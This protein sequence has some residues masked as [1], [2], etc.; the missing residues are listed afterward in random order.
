MREAMRWTAPMNAPSP[1]PTMPSLILLPVL[2]SLRP[3]MAMPVS[4]LAQSDRAA[5]E[6]VERFVGDPDDVMLDELGALARA[7]LRVLEAAFPFEH[8]PGRIAVLRHL[9]KDAREVGLPVAER[10]EPP[11]PF[12]PRRIARIDALP[13]RRIELGVLHMKCRNPLVVDV[14]ELEIVELLQDEMRGI[15]IDG[16][17]LVSF[18]GVE[19]TLEA[20][21][22]EQVLARVDLVGD[23]DAG[24][25]EG[26]QDRLPALGE[27]FVRGLDQPR[28]A[29]RPRIDIGPGERTRE[30]RMGRE[31]E[32]LR[33]LGGMQHLL[34]RPLLPLLW[35]PVSLLRG[36]GVEGFVIGRVDRDQ[37]TDHMRRE[38]GNRQTVVLR[39][40]G[41][42]VAIGL[43]R[44]GFGE[45]EEP[46]LPG[47]NLDALIAER[48]RP[49]A[50]P[51]QRIE[52]RSVAGELRQEYCRSLDHASH[53]PSSFRALAR[54]TSKGEAR[55]RASPTSRRS[56]RRVREVTVLRAAS[57]MLA[58]R[59]HRESPFVKR[60]RSRLPATPPSG[61]QFEQGVM[62][63]VDGR[64]VV[65]R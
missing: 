7:V 21:S 17:A 43:R 60:G 26:V 49:L 32:V 48:S 52:R 8:R 46:S 13:P 51:V 22:V 62:K 58:R 61:Q 33:R 31:A 3:S 18:D 42:L 50:H 28:R 16:A 2:A 12:D 27:L 44:G 14:D 37:L 9:R 30:G 57:N 41:D 23:V 29:L 20:R 53:D 19:E 65:S 55:G 15:V 40:P 6:V 47:R 45:V 24:L 34:N 39:G 5:G 4:P 36:E 56:E 54:L 38:L 11:G 10:P 63:G 59:L 64:D 35:L 1:P 25:V